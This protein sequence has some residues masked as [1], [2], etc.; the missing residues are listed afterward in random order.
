MALSLSENLFLLVCKE[1]SRNH[2]DLPSKSGFDRLSFRKQ[3]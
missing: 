2:R 1:F 3:F